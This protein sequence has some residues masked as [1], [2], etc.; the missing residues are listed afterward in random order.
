M[1]LETIKRLLE[2][3]AFKNTEV[4]YNVWLEESSGYRNYDTIII[5]VFVEVDKTIPEFPGYDYKYNNTIYRTEDLVSSALY[6]RGLPTDELKY[7]VTFEYIDMDEM[8]EELNKLTSE[9]RTTLSKEFNIS[10]ELLSSSNIGFYFYG[11]ESDNA[12]MRIELDGE[13][14]FDPDTDELLIENNDVIDV[15]AD[16]YRKS[17]LNG[18][19]ELDIFYPSY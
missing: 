9:L 1:K 16:I 14:L 11:S 8:D 10:D 5:E 15:A 4:E 19:L 13:A 6:F 3:L 17:R 2:D 12:Y 18:E 7:W